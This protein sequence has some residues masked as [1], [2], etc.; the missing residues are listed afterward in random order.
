MVLESLVVLNGMGAIDSPE[1]FPAGY[2]KKKEKFTGNTYTYKHF[3]RLARIID[4]NI[5]AMGDALHSGIVPA[6][7][8]GEKDEGKMC[9]YCSYR[10]ICGYEIGDEIREISKLSHTDALKAL[11]GEDDE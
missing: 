1:Y 3:R 2:D 9:K 6:V 8:T 5:K 7:P 4:G 10:A 11:G